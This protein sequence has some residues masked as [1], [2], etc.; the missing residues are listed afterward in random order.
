VNRDLEGKNE[1]KTRRQIGRIAQRFAVKI[2]LD[3]SL[4]VQFAALR[5]T[6]DSFD[7]GSAD[8]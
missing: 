7:M 6:N 8:V 3:A 5:S 1:M 2:G 4:M